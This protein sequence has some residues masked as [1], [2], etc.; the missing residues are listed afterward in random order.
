MAVHVYTR[1]VKTLRLVLPLL[2]G[3]GLLSLLIWPWWREQQQMHDDQAAASKAIGA[4]D[5]GTTAAPLQVEKPDY[6]GIDAKGRAYRITAARV[7]QNLNPKAPITLIEPKAMLTLD[8]NPDAATVPRQAALQAL[9][10][11]YD[12]QAQTLDLRGD[13]TLHYTG[14]YVIT[15]QDLTVDI[16]SGVAVST[17]PVEGHGSRG[18]LSARSLNIADK[19]GTIV[20]N[21]PSRLVLQPKAASTV[22]LPSVSVMPKS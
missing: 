9:R 17:T 11:V 13:V 21:G 6:Q 5:T 14:D 12:A 15:M 2:A 1:Y 16:V 20:L 8:S 19:G 4:T 3:L 10:G 22:P 7:E 18:F